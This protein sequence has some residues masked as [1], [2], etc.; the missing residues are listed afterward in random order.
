LSDPSFFSLELAWEKTS[1]TAVSITAT[2]A[3][4]TDTE[5][6]GNRY[7]LAFYITEDGV[8]PY[9]QS[10]YYSGGSLGS[11]GGWESKGSTVE[12]YY[13]DV[14][15]VLMGG[16][17]GYA[18]S[19]PESLEAGQEYTY[20]CNANISTVDGDEFFITGLLIDNQ[21]GCI[22]NARQTKASK[23]EEGGSGLSDIEKSGF[24]VYGGNGTVNFVGEYDSAFVYNVAGHLVATAHGESS[25]ALPAGLYIVKAGDK[26][27]KIAVK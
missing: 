15:R 24:A 26:T 27:A 19:L 8:G 20:S 7:R 22:V 17:T 6:P 18:S 13:D 2:T 12:T 14:A 4:A 23:T 5:N 16:R 9:K 1:E 10:N 25:V 21:T 11:M 3:V